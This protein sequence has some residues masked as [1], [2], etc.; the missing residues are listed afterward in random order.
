MM[1]YDFVARSLDRL[2][3]LISET[4]HLLWDEVYPVLT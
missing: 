3:M 2:P 4:E 1:V